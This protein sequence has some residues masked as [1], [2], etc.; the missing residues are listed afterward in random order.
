MRNEVVGK[1]ETLGNVVKVQQV[2]DFMV[3]GV[4]Q[5]KGEQYNNQLEQFV[6][7]KLGG[8]GVNKAYL[9][10]RL[11]KMYELGYVNRRWEGD[12]RFN[13]FYT[14]T[15]DGIAYFVRLRREL[16]ERVEMAQKV[17]GLFG[18]YI[19]EFDGKR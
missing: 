14:I 3:L 9:T 16:P 5:Q 18:S 15:E 19:E 4:I 17:Y 12:N 13:R 2:I 11:A 10:T 1:D 6:V 8:I 7:S